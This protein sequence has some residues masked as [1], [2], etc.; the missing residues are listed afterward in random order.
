MNRHGL[1]RV[2]DSAGGTEAAVG[3]Q[4]IVRDPMS[5]ASAPD[6]SRV[7]G[8]HFIEQAHAAL[9]RYVVLDPATI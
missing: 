7:P 2:L 4:R 6:P 1:G 8:Q 5:R 3:T 9:V